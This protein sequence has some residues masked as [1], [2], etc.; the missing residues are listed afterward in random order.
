[1]ILKPIPL[2][3]ILVKIKH[4]NGVEKNESTDYL[5]NNK[6]HISIHLLNEIIIFLQKEKNI[7]GQLLGVNN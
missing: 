2:S 4:C 1:M 5:K 3:E 7:L 6:D